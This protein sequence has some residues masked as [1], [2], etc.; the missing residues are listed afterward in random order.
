MSLFGRLKERL[1]RTRTT[2]SDGLSGLFRGGRAIDP[3]LLSELEELLYNADLG[4][5]ATEVV[6]ELT[7][8]HKRGELKGEGDYIAA[9][10][11]THGSIGRA[12]YYTTFTIVIG[13]SIL[14]FSNFIPSVLFGLFTGLAIAMALLAALTL[15]PV[16]LIRFKPFKTDS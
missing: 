4:A 14:V 1:K 2:L 15:L 3:A 6:A 8:L 12:L 10:H 9:M 7:R 11:R 13:F 16:M 5:A